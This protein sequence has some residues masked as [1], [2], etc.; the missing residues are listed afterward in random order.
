MRCV[1]QEID[2]KTTFGHQKKH[3]KNDKNEQ[4]IGQNGENMSNIKQELIICSCKK[5]A[6]NHVYELEFDKK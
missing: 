2:L 3:T 5:V 4:M 1:G 6:R